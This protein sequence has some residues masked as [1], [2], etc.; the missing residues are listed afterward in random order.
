MKRT[1]AW[2]KNTTDWPQRLPE[3]EIEDS[4]TALLVVDICNDSETLPGVLPNI[5]KLRNFYR[6]QGLKVIYCLIGSFLPDGR[7]RHIKC[8]LTW[9][10]SSA[11]EPEKIRAKGTFLYQVKEELRPLLPGELV[12]DKNSASA[13]ESSAI[14]HYLHAM[15]IQNLVVCG[16]TTSKCVEN[17]ARAAADRGYNTIL[18]EDACS[19]RVHENQQAT[20]HTFAQ[21]LGAVKSTQEVIDDLSRSTK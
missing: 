20:F 5:I 15:D 12:I 6:Q 9:H 11:S 1:I 2:Q 14:D 3:L 19:D 4:K 7:D 10:R 17:T 16:M 13:F 18:V 8:R 21:Y